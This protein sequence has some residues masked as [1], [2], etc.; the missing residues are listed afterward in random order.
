MRTYDSLIIGH[1]TMDRNTDC[2]G[3]TVCAAGGA[4]LFSSAAARALGHKVC[5][6]TK[7]NEKERGRLSAFT[8]PPEDVICLPA[9]HGANMENTYFTA[10]KERRRCVCVSQGDPIA[11]EDIPP[12]VAGRIYHLAGLVA[13][14]FAAGIIP[15]LARR[16]PVAVDV[17]GYLR[18]VDRANGGTMF[19]RDWEEKKELLPLISFLKTDAAEAEILTGET[20]RAAAAK[21][22]HRWGAREIL[23]TH[24]TEVLVYDG[25]EL[26]TCP[27]RARNLSGRTGRGDTTFAAYLT[28]RLTRGPAAA[29]KTATAAVSLKMETPGPLAATRAEIEAYEAE[30]YPDE[31]LTI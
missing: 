1:I 5:V 17:Q 25:K 28:E 23:I 7:A 12:D 30:F 24:N 27:I 11:A 15:A 20:D 29:L 21:L 16:G 26:L 4:V 6:L 8:I 19:F 9:E 10:D 3:R 2:L 13:G 31:H 14:D 22:L 18:R